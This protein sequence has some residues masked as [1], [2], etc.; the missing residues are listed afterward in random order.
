MKI[1]ASISIF[2]ILFTVGVQGQPKQLKTLGNGVKIVEDFENE[3]VGTLPQRWY[4]YKA[5]MAVPQFSQDERAKYKYKV[6]QKKD[7]KF[8]RYSGTKAMH[9]TFPL[10]K[11]EELNI[12]ETPILSWKWR[13]WDLPD[14]AS[15]DDKND[16]A[17]S[18]YV[19]FDLGH[20][21]FKKVP[22]SIRYTWS[23]TLETGTELSKFFGNQKIIVVA[24]GK[25]GLGRWRTFERNIVE[26]YKRLFGDSPPEKPLAILILSDGDNTGNTAI[27]DYDDIKLKPSK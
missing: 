22:K 23:S 27:A 21:L 5:D 9:L 8:L 14:G 19:V 15:E 16:T 2:L 6:M 25:N 12:F 7:N 20:V 4:D 13:V 10:R 18:I 17:A 24:S 11:V 1:T 26:D 3:K